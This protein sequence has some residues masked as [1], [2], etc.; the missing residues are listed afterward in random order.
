M[1]K[2]LAPHALIIGSVAL[3]AAV[4]VALNSGSIGGL[5]GTMA[6]IAR[7]PLPTVAALVTGVA[8]RRYSYL[9]LATLAVGVGVSLW[10]GMMVAEQRHLLGL[11]PLGLADQLGVRLYVFAVLSHVANA[12]RLMFMRP[13]AELPG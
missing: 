4:G 7:D 2:P 9:L 6:G 11:R 1:A 5:L 13:R 12:A 3:L 10:V 8:F